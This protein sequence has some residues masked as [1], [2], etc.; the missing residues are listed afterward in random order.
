MKLP[1]HNRYDFIPIDQRPDYEWPGSKRL[2]VVFCNNIEHFA[3][4][5]GLGSD[6][7][8]GASPQNQRNW[9]WKDYGN[10]VGL[11]RYL[12]LLD[13]H[14]IPGSHNINSSVLEQYPEIAK[15]LVQRGDEFIG[16]GR[17]NAERQDTLWEEDE[18]RLIGESTEAIARISGAKPRG[19][20]GPYF[21]QSK[22]TLD[23]LKEAGYDYVLD[24]PA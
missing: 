8:S 19:W 18:A 21:A 22:V 5:A 2:A 3:F 17:T 13:E 23:L 20:L 6:N 4:S 9:A 16:H 24:W 7:A 14:E 12:D 15:R 1:N 10:R 11:W